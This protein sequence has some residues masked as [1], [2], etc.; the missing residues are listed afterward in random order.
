M[1]KLKQKAPAKKITFS[2][3]PNKNFFYVLLIAIAM[4]LVW[5]G[6][7]DLVDMYL[8][9]EHPVWSALISFFIGLVILYLPDQDIKELL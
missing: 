5:R 6:V 8:F 9:P 4:I 1:K 7:W 2:L 3:R